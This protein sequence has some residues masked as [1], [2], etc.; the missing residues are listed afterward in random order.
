MDGWEGRLY[1]ERM[2]GVCG[3]CMGDEVKVMYDIK[4]VCVC[5]VCI[6]QVSSRLFR[7]EE[8]ANE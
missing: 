3:V 1:R 6:D 2:R 5:T 4:Y 7:G 8:E